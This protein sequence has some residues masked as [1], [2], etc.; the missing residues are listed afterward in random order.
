VSR[1]PR[2]RTSAQELELGRRQPHG[3]AGAAHRPRREV[4]LDVAQPMASGVAACRDAAQ[5][6]AQARDELLRRDGRGQVVVRARLETADQLVL[7]A[8]GGHEDQRHR[9]PLAQAPAQ[10]DAAAVRQRGS[11]DSA[12]RPAERGAAACAEGRRWSPRR[13]RR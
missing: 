12:V 13:R 6:R 5:R 4:D 8:V 7:V 1:R 11:D 3:L 9:A 10:V 2:R